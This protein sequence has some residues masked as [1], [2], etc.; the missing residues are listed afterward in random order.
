VIARFFS[1]VTERQFDDDTPDPDYDP[2]AVIERWIANA[3]AKGGDV[4]RR[5]W[6]W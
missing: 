4:V 1:W 5:A 3:R 2:A 6:E